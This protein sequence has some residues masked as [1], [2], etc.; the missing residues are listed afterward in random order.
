MA[1]GNIPAINLIG[2]DEVFFSLGEEFGVIKDRIARKIANLFL[3]FDAQYKPENELEIESE[4][5]RVYL[6][7]NRRDIRK[8]M[9]DIFEDFQDNLGEDIDIEDHM[10][11]VLS[12]VKDFVAI[13]THRKLMRQ[14]GIDYTDLNNRGIDLD[15]GRRKPFILCMFAKFELFI[16]YFSYRVGLPDSPP[17][18]EYKPKLYKKIIKRCIRMGNQNGGM[19]KR[20]LGYIRKRR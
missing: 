4:L 9:T 11:R 2:E 18:K 19:I 17:L 14:V 8:S 15:A 6:D 12:M 1:D 5:L 10:D 20:R 16:E 13:H 3:Q 7:Q